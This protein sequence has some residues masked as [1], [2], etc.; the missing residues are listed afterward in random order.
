MASDFYL[1]VEGVERL[2]ETILPYRTLLREVMPY[3][4]QIAIREECGDRNVYYA[5]RLVGIRLIVPC[6][7]RLDPAKSAAAARTIRTTPDIRHQM[8]RYIA[9]IDEKL[10]NLGLAHD[11]AEAFRK[12]LADSRG[13]SGDLTGTA[14]IVIGAR[15]G[16]RITPPSYFLAHQDICDGQAGNRQDQARQQR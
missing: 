1:S 6:P 12:R 16:R 13:H 5:G 7:I 10:D 9:S 14:S 15:F 8:T 3:D 11:Q 2:L 4:L